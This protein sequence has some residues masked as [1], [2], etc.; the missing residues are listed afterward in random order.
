MGRGCSLGSGRAPRTKHRRTGTKSARV[1]VRSTGI[2][3]LSEQEEAGG[4]QGRPSEG[5][6]KRGGGCVGKLE[7]AESVRKEGTSN[8]LGCCGIFPGGVRME[9]SVPFST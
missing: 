2:S 1:S 6:G 8:S 7:W 9:E 3:E 4:K 5:G